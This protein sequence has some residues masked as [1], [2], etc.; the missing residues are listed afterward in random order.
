MFLAL[1][2]EA[3]GPE[4]KLAEI[5]DGIVASLHG[6]KPAREGKRIRYPGEETLR[7]RAENRNLGLPVEP[8]VWDE[9]LAL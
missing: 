1:N 7:V 2:P 3:L 8:G 5:A 6:S 4:P 9:I